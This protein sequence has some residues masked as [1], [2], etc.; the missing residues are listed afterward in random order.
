MPPFPFVVVI[1]G[2]HTP[3]DGTIDVNTS[4]H[5]NPIVTCTYLYLT[6]PVTAVQVEVFSDMLSTFDSIPI[7]QTR[8][9]GPLDDD[10]SLTKTQYVYELSSSENIELCRD[11]V[12][13]SKAV[14]ET[15]VSTGCVAHYGDERIPHVSGLLW[16]RTEAYRR[17]EGIDSEC[18]F[19]TDARLAVP[20][21]RISEP[22]DI[23]HTRFDVNITLGTCG[24][25][26]VRC[27]GVLSILTDASP[28]VQLYFAYTW[29]CAHDRVR[30]ARAIELFMY[31]H[32]PALS[33]TDCGIVY[34][35]DGS[36]MRAFGFTPHDVPTQRPWAALCA[37]LGTTYTPPIDTTYTLTLS[38]AEY[39]FGNAFAA[40]RYILKDHER[41]RG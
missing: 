24:P 14:E 12:L 15:I 5:G 3:I 35:D 4:A 21:M 13:A 11:F 2:S 1:D 18:E 9:H 10:T 20:E 26:D 8:F 28:L 37:A 36:E 31:N 17:R 25:T 7:V 39:T 23:H 34:N 32:N 33:V 27:V 6:N 22:E 40:M 38:H 41:S 19:P 29:V 30:I 16:R